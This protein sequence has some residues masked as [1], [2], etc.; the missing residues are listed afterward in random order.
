MSKNRNLWPKAIDTRKKRKRRR[1]K[2]KI[3]MKKRKLKC[4]INS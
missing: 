1:K 3:N 2:M 4:M